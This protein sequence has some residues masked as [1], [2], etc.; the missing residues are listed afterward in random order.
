MNR[1][2]LLRLL[3]GGGGAPFIYQVSR[4]QDSVYFSVGLKL[5][6]GSLI[7]TNIGPLLEDYKNVAEQAKNLAANLVKANETL[8]KNAKT[9]AVVN[10]EAV[11]IEDAE[12]IDV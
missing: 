3:M 1:A 7:M 11:E 12:I 8:Q 2:A 9:P 10:A 6:A 4:E 5:V